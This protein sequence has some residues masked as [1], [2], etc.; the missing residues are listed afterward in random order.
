MALGTIVLFRIKIR[1]KLRRFTAKIDN[2]L[3]NS[4]A[5]QFLTYLNTKDLG[6]LH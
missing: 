5:L 4:K 3:K 2:F 1:L 6:I